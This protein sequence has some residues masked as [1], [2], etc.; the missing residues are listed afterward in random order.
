MSWHLAAQMPT[1]LVL[2]ALEPA[3]TLRRP[4][5]GLI[6]H[7]DRGSQYT[8]GACRQRIADAGA[9]ASYARPSNTSDNAQAKVG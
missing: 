8:S 4:A 2:T 3:L 5:L 1:G 6:I 7:A 9:V